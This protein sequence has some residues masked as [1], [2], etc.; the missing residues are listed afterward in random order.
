V[1]SLPPNEF[2]YLLPVPSNPCPATPAA[3]GAPLSFDGTYFSPKASWLIA[4]SISVE[5]GNQAYKPFQPQVLLPHREMVRIKT[6][7]ATLTAPSTV[8]TI[9]TP[10]IGGSGVDSGWCSGAG[11]RAAVVWVM[12]DES[13]DC[14]DI[15]ND[16]PWANDEWFPDF[17]KFPSEIA[18]RDA[19]RTSYVQNWLS[20]TA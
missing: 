13:D 8:S 4:K 2:D 6:Y 1:L 14:E 12:E 11:E 18:L 10:D 15:D 20:N 5:M 16:D 7:S 17:L 9:L 3:F 19:R